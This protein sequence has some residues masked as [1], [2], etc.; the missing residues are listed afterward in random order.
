MN[1]QRYSPLTTRLPGEAIAYRP[2]GAV[3][4]CQFLAAAKKLS[5][6]L[7]PHK[8]V[9][10]LYSDRYQ[11]L[12]GFCASVI[13]GQCTLLP[14]NK[15]TRTLEHLADDYPD[16]YVLGGSD[17]SDNEVFSTEGFGELASADCEIPNIRDDIP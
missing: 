14:P 7:P 11:Y 4:V 6:Q 17:S 5:Q 2:D 10:N 12:L 3:L 1:T 16:S 9:F 15:L 8:Y 13:A